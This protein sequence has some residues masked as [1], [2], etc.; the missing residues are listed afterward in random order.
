MQ[1]DVMQAN[2]GHNGD[3]GLIAL[4]PS[5]V[6]ESFDLTIECFNLAE[7]YRTPVF[8]AADQVVA[9][10]TD[11]L[12]IP[13]VDEIEVSER[14][15]APRDNHVPFNFDNDFPP[16]SIAGAGHR[17][18]VDSLTHDERGYP[19]TS[20]LV[21]RKMLDHIVGKIRRHS[22]E[23]VEVEHHL[24]EDADVIVVAYGS[25]SRSALRAVSDARHAGQKVGLLRLITP[26]PFPASEIER[27]GSR[28]K[29]IVVPEINYGQMEHPVKEHASCPVIGIYHAAGSLIQPEEISSV[30]ERL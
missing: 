20:Q 4:S 7:K 9:H 22:G 5:S 26:W 16:M 19:S 2:Y 25:T 12:V 24:T 28:A 21:S 13:P 14:I 30:L 3:I 17:M 29:A 1:G 6:Q 27:I 15:R 8:V 11:R 18:N 23:I 10:M